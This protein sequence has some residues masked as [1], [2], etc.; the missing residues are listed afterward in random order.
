MRVDFEKNIYAENDR[1]IVTVSWKQL[2]LTEAIKDNNIL[3]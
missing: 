2:N 3:V 1:L